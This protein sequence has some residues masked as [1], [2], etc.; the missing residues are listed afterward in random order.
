MQIRFR[1]R[2]ITRYEAGRGVVRAKV[3]LTVQ[4]GSESP[5]WPVI[6]TIEMDLEQP[7]LFDIGDDF[8]VT[9]EAAE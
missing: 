4:H 3:R 8:L 6:G 2:E 5:P 7:G 9:F 1:V